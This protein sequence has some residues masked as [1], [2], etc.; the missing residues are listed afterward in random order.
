MAWRNIEFDQLISMQSLIHIDSARAFDDDRTTS[1]DA[2]VSA[3]HSMDA[4]RSPMEQPHPSTSRQDPVRTAGMR[5]SKRLVRKLM[6]GS[7]SR[8]S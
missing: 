6:P 8:A 2:R 3:D 4:R 5:L 7:Y 1:A